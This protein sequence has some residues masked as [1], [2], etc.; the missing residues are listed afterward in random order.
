[1]PAIT[2]S[3]HTPLD[4]SPTSAA[5]KSTQTEFNNT[6]HTTVK[7]PVAFTATSTLQYCLHPQTND[8]QAER[9][10]N[11]IRRHRLQPRHRVTTTYKLLSTMSTYTKSSGMCNIVSTFQMTTV[12][13]SIYEHKKW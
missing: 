9:I 7:L 3:H 6:P 12:E 10:P 5:A 2:T 8:R 4:T 13:L 11:D 1:M